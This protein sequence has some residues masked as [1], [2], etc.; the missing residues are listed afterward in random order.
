MGE[1]ARRKHDEV[2]V[3][4]GTCE[5]MYYLRYTQRNDV[6]FRSP[7]PIDALWFRLPRPEENALWLATLRSTATWAQ[8]RCLSSSRLMRKAIQ[9]L[10]SKHTLLKLSS[11]ALNRQEYR[12]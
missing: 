12:K 1:Y 4:V 2:E 7:C 6:V 3:K 11:I 9:A 5:S 8:N 10:R